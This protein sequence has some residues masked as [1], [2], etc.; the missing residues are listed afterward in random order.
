M[1]GVMCSILIDQDSHRISLHTH[2]HKY[3]I[4]M[5]TLSLFH[6]WLMNIRLQQYFM[7]DPP[8]LSGLPGQVSNALTPSRD[9][10]VLGLGDDDPGLT[11]NVI[12]IYTYI[13]IHTYTVSM[14]IYI[15]MY[16]LY[17]YIYIYT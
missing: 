12:Y 6:L 3:I 9:V 17:I 13:F 4:H 1:L 15:Y 16:N 7:L 11:K 10:L 14:Y 8:V 2:V 5:Y